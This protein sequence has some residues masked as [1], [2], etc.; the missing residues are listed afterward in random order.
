MKLTLGGLLILIAVFLI[1][2]VQRINDAP[3]KFND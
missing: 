3:G 2:I 1:F